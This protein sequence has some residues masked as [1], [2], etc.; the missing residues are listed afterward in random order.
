MSLENIKILTLRPDNQESW[1]NRLKDLGYNAKNI[2]LTK[3]V[4]NNF[5]EKLKESILKV[6]DYKTIITS[7]NTFRYLSNFLLENKSFTNQKLIVLSRNLK[8]FA[9]TFGFAEIEISEDNYST[10]IAKNFIN[11]ND[12]YI[13]LGAEEPS[14]EW[15]DYLKENQHTYINIYKTEPT[16]IDLSAKTLLLENY[17]FVLFTNPLSI[18]ILDDEIWRNLSKQNL[19]AIGKTTAQAIVNKGYKKPLIMESPDFDSFLEIIKK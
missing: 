19:V 18:E 8:E 6:K 9:I 12:Y 17:D 16:N 7:K 3:T 4:K 11:T 13:I 5:E 14:L 15:S 1:S 10:S 2:S